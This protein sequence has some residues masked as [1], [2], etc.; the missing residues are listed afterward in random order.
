MTRSAKPTQPDGLGSEAGFILIAVLWL[1]TALATL[2]SIYSAYA[3][4]SAVT[5][6]IPDDRLVVEAAIRAGVE[7]AAYRELSVS[8]SSRPTHGAF[9]TEVGRTK[10]SVHFQSEAARIDLNAAPKELLTGLFVAL[11][12]RKSAADGYADRVIGWREKAEA[13]SDHSEAEGYK[14]AG[15]AYAPRGAPFDDAL[16]LSL[17]MG[18]PPAIVERMLSFVTVYSGK[19]QVDVVE[20]SPEALAALPGV[21]PE[22]VADVL[23]AR[24]GGSDGKTLIERLGPAGQAVTI[25]PNDATRVAVLVET[26]SGRR[27]QAE[28]VIRLTEDK[29]SPFDIL[30]W[31]DDFDGPMR[32][33]DRGTDLRTRLSE[34]AAA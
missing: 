8:K 18:L 7:L 29:S 4:N 6:R 21:T 13:N 16:E 14:Q 15:L 31:R 3:I 17:V 34:K 20:A 30:Y 9:K 33:A 25:E 27:I 12:V 28:L 5:A 32:R 11:G 24:A 1:L 19:A 22:A 2:A 10:I 26:S 23:Q